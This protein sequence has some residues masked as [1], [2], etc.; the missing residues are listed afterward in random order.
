[1]DENEIYAKLKAK[2]HEIAD[3][4]DQIKSQEQLIKGY[5]GMLQDPRLIEAGA[6]L[7]Q[8]I[9]NIIEDPTIFGLPEEAVTV[10]Q[11]R[12]K[13]SSHITGIYSDIAETQIKIIQELWQVIN[14]QSDIKSDII[15]VLTAPDNGQ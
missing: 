1:M 5:E 15:G 3:V 13:F 4:L 14:I 7:D 9:K 12:Q 2:Q 8:T 6:K 11:E 10:L